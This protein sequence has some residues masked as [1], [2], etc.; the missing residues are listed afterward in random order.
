MSDLDLPVVGQAPPAGARERA[1]ATRNRQRVLAAASDL[2]AQSDPTRITMDAIARAAGVGRATLYRRYAGVASVAVALLDEHERD[3]Q[4]RI[5]RG[6]PPLG[7]GAAPADRLAA[8]YAAMVDVLEQHAHLA[9]GAEVG[10]S[11]FAPGAYQFWSA[12]VRLLLETAGMPDP[13][14]LVDI[15]LA[16]LAPEVYLH[17]RRDSGQTPEQIAAALSR[18]AHSLLGNN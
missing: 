9:L 12:H 7:P 8:F 13:V 16:P 5:L 4:E 2:F 10:R 14:A 18:V 11:R 15:L 3:L 17:Q 6:E 1:D